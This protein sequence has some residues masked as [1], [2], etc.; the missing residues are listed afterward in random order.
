MEDI[1]FQQQHVAEQMWGLQG[2]HCLKTGVIWKERKRITLLC[3]AK[4][5]SKGEW[6]YRLLAVQ[7]KILGGALYHSFLQ[8]K[9]SDYRTACANNWPLTWVWFWE[10]W[11]VLPYHR[12]HYKWEKHCWCDGPGPQTT[13]GS[14]RPPRAL[15]L[16]H[17]RRARRVVGREPEHARPPPPTTP[18]APPGKEEKE[19]PV[20]L[21][22]CCLLI[23]A[24]V[25]IHFIKSIDLIYK[26][27]GACLLYFPTF[28]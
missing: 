24:A 18:P 28:K 20:L 25:N 5:K 17:C 27:L 15:Q 26:L 12:Q 23:Y 7:E 13:P 8:N 11:S 4:K 3:E 19:D 16:Q 10:M 2:L 14:Q 22:L 9:W 21:F 1:C 6:T